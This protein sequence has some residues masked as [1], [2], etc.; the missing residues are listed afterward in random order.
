[1]NRYHKAGET[2]IRGNSDKRCET[3]VGYDANALYL[4]S[5]DQEMPSGPFV[6]RKAEND[7]KPEKRDRYSLMYD[8]MDYVVKTYNIKIEH[9]L[10]TGKE[11]KVGPFPEDG[12]DEHNTI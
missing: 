7:F 12:F 1:M 8:W 5:I 2:F 6:R 4:W 9:K 10:N 3:I 11:K